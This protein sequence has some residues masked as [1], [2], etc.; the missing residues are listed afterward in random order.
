MD[1][2]GIEGDETFPPEGI[3]DWLMIHRERYVCAWD[4]RD[5]IGFYL[6]DDGTR[7]G[8]R[9]I[10]CDLS[11]R[12]LETLP[13]ILRSGPI[14]EITFFQRTR[15]RKIW[16]GGGKW[17]DLDE[18]EKEWNLRNSTRFRLISS[19]RLN[20]FFPWNAA[21]V[22]R[23]MYHREPI[24]DGDERLLPIRWMHRVRERERDTFYSGYRTF[25][26]GRRWRNVERDIS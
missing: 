8:S 5:P 4:S 24:Y 17:M 2:G 10:A 6:I 20:E 12:F 14:I 11:R 13:V 21:R 23:R 25:T 15:I 9:P 7:P 26:L 18:E 22:T 1:G 19:L 3:G 16:G